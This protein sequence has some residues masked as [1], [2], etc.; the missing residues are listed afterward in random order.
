MVMVSAPFCPPWML[1]RSRCAFPHR[2]QAKFTS[3]SSVGVGRKSMWISMSLEPGTGYSAHDIT[4]RICCPERE[5]DV[6]A[7]IP[8]RFHGTVLIFTG[9][10]PGYCAATV[11]RAGGRFVNSNLPP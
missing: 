7:E 3:Q 8:L 11:Y 9:A 1:S 5:G 4:K 6:M 10:Y 2:V